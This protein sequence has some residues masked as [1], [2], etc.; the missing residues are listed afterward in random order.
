MPAAWTIDVCMGNR[1]TR[2]PLYQSDEP[3]LVPYEYVHSQS[4]VRGIG[5]YVVSI[6]VRDRDGNVMFRAG[7]IVTMEKYYPDGKECGGL[8]F[9]RVLKLTAGRELVVQPS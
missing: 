5:P 3:G 6:S 4:A 7:R 2:E 9:V 8:C 1:C